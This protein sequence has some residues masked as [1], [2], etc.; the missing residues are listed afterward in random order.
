MKISH[1]EKV[2]LNRERIFLPIATKTNAHIPPIAPKINST[3][4]VG[5]LGEM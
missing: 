1:F 4:I 5:H 3:M 2:C